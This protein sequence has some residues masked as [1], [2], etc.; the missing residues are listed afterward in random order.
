MI[1]KFNWTC[2]LG[3]LELPLAAEGKTLQTL[4]SYKRLKIS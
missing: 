2:N 1:M 3:G 4:I